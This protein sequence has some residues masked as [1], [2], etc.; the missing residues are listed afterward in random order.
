MLIPVILNN[1]V[2]NSKQTILITDGEKSIRNALREIL[3]CGDYLI[4]EAE[5]GETA[6]YVMSEQPV[7]LIILYIKMK[8]MDGMEVLSRLKENQSEVPVIMI[9]GHGTI[10]IA[11]EATKLGA[12]DFLE[13]PPD[14]NRLLISVR[15][16]LKNHALQ[17]ENRQIRTQLTEAYEIIGESPASCRE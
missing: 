5:N 17:R 4:L 10:K 14:L 12:Y 9:S 15:N 1:V 3:E 2:L 11:V 6:V 13:K 7:V 16:A 8:G